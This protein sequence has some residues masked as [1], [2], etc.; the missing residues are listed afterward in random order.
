MNI[1]FTKGDSSLSQLICYVTDEPVSH[2]ALDFGWFI[3]H[4]NLRGLHL[5]WGPSFRA[6]TE[7]VFVLER[8]DVSDNLLDMNRLD[9]LLTKYEFSWY[10]FGALLFLGLS[11]AARKYLKLPLPKSNLWQTSGM[12]LCTEWATDYLTGKENSLITPYKLYRELKST[13]QWKDK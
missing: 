13:G 11:F 8:T 2:V 10:D 5:T 4:S 12:F 1:L 6:R 9:R 7:V 3:V